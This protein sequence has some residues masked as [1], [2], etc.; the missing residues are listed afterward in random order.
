MVCVLITEDA[1]MVTVQVPPAP[2]VQGLVAGRASWR[3]GVLT[4]PVGVPPPGP[5]LSV[6]VTVAV[7]DWP[8]LSVEDTSVI[9]VVVLRRVTVS[10]VVPVDVSCVASP[11]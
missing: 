7:V 11:V 3:E 8:T 1:V 2:S 9:E 5:A 10:E 4:V 6:T